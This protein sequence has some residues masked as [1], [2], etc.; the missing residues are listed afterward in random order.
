MNDSIRDAMMA[1]VPSLSAQFAA[2]FRGAFKAAGESLGRK[3]PANPP[4]TDRC[5]LLIRETVSRVCRAYGLNA[6]GFPVPLDDMSTFDRSKQR[7]A[8]WLEIDESLLLVVSLR[9]AER[10]ATEWL[11]KA[12][13]KLGEVTEAELSGLGGSFRIRAKRGDDVVILDQG[14]IVNCSSKGR[15]FNQ[16]PARLYLNGH[17]AEYHKGAACQA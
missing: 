5:Y 14:M 7:R 4:A 2:Q 10:A 11:R 9:A 16:Y 15:L 3:V 13:A 17:E 12:N 1:R 6:Q 8:A